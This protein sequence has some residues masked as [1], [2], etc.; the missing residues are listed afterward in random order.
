MDVVAANRASVMTFFVFPANAGIQ[1]CVDDERP[2][3]GHDGSGVV[4]S[5]NDFIAV[6]SS[7]KQPAVH[8]LASRRNGTLYIGVTSNLQERIWQHKNGM[9]E[10]FTKKYDVHMWVYY[11]LLADMPT[12][13]TREKQLKKWNRDWKLHLIEEGNPDWRDLWDDINV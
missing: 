8:I 11:E 10:G 13:I 1:P 12:A 9:H 6:R 4:V 5:T 3:F 2:R 7:M